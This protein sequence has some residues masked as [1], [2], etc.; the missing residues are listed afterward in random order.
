MQSASRSRCCSPAK[1]TS[2]CRS[3][4]MH[5]GMTYW[6]RCPSSWCR[7]ATRP[8]LAPIRRSSTD[9]GGRFWLRLPIHEPIDVVLGIFAKAEPLI[10]PLRRIEFF[11]RNADFLGAEPRLGKHR[12][13]QRG[14]DAAVA[15]VRQQ[16][17]VDDEERLVLAIEIKPACRGAVVLENVES[18]VGKVSQVVPPLR[19]ELTFQESDLLLVGPVGD[20][21]ELLPTGRNVETAQELDVR[22]GLGTQREAL[23]GKDRGH[24]Q[25]MHRAGGGVRHVRGRCAVKSKRGAV[26]SGMDKCR[27]AICRSLSPDRAAYCRAA[28]SR[29][30]AKSRCPQTPH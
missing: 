29:R 27:T 6:V 25:A 3:A 15:P 18:R 2:S 22:L 14:A 4:F 21:R 1:A 30:Q 7:S 24:R 10:E 26:S 17:E 12:F 8:A 16:R 5:C 19:R 9:L 28:A 20:D 23:L 13:D 11:D